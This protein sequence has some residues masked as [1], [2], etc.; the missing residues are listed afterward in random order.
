MNI[1]KSN[2]PE[3]SSDQIN[4][5]QS[6]KELYEFWNKKINVISR[7]DITEINTRHILHSMSIAKIIRFK[8]KSKI[9]DVGTGGGFPGIPLSILNP[10]SEFVL[11]DSIEKKI[12]VVNSIVKDLDLKN[13]SPIR[14][15]SEKINEKFDFIVCRAVSKMTDF[16]KIVDGKI[17]NHN[18]NDFKNGIFYLKGGDLSFE[19][20]KIDNYKIFEIKNLFKDSF[21]ESK[22]IVYIPIP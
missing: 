18:K 2:F 3:L 21:F 10:E 16:L 6:L 22:K 13:V 15:R 1:F 14:E 20:N 8:K 17:S 4:K 12:K 11:S 7:K 5:L 9:L 19:L